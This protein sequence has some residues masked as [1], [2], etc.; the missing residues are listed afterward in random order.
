MIEFDLVD[1]DLLPS[2]VHFYTHFHSDSPKP[3]KL[4]Y[5]YSKSGSP[6]HK[7]LILSQ[8]VQPA[9]RLSLVISRV[10][11][12]EIETLGFLEGKI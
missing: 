10:K 4:S 2:L 3:L 12:E 7:A 11:S 1:L 5:H 9:D 6:Q 8:A